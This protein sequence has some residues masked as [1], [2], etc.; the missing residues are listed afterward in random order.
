MPISKAESSCAGVTR[1]LR[2]V[3]RERDLALVRALSAMQDQRR[4]GR[5]ISLRLSRSKAGG[6]EYRPQSHQGL[7]AKQ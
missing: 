3:K 7:R 4:V 2:T 1:L 5:E 6:P